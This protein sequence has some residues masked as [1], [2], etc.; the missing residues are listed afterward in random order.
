MA[1]FRPGLE[2]PDGTDPRRPGA[3]PRAGEPRARRR[4]AARARLRRLRDRLRVGILDGLPV[5]RAARRAR[6]R[7]RRRTSGARAPLRLGRAPRDERAEVVLGARR[8]RPQRR[9]RGRYGAEV[10]VFHP[11]FLLG[12]SREDAIDVGRG[13]ARTRPR[14]ARGEVPRGAVRDRGDGP[15]AR[16]RLAGRLRRDQP[17]R[18]LGAAGDRLRAHAR[19]ERRRVTWSPSRSARRSSSPTACSSRARR[20]TSTSPTSR[21]RTATRRSTSPTARGRC[22]PT[23][24]ARRSRASRGPRR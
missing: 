9:D 1:Q 17:P 16:P 5:G 19:D 10:V 21:S 8:A 3:D 14:A 23:R 4:R 2:S 22:A 15:R 13:A 12:R 7:E 11:G 6:P 24:S 20:S 18:G